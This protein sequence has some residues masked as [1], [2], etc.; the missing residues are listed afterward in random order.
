MHLKTGT[1]PV[2]ELYLA[3]LDRERD[4]VARYLGLTSSGMG[5]RLW[6]AIPVLSDPSSDPAPVWGMGSGDDLERRARAVLAAMNIA[7]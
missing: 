7:V 3:V 6:L 4:Q 2:L 5:G 1:M